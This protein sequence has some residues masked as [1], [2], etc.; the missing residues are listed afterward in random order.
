MGAGLLLA[1]LRTGAA[2]VVALRPV[3]IE[4]VLHERATELGKTV[5]TARRHLSGAESG[6]EA[7]CG[8]DSHGTA[9]E[10]VAGSTLTLGAT[11]AQSCNPAHT[12][13]DLSCRVAFRSRRPPLWRRHDILGAVA[14][15]A[16]RPWRPRGRLA[17]K[18]RQR[19]TDPG[20][21][22]RRR[23]RRASRATSGR[24]RACSAAR[25][26]RGRTGS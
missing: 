18:T 4:Q 17:A 15:A 7:R 12:L 9:R 1:P 22:R 13:A 25:A 20:G 19:G 16:P 21:V 6:G 24:G 8:P 2:H 23:Y 3:G 11:Q 14:I 26:G 5:K 10:S